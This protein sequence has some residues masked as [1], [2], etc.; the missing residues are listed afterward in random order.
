MT[1]KPSARAGEGQRTP[2]TP[3]T[4]RISHVGAEGDGVGAGPDGTLY[5]VPDTL[6]NES[7][8]VRPYQKAGQGWLARVT[9][10]LIPSPSRV[11]PV[12][13]H[14][15][16]CGGCVLQHWQSDEYAAWKASQVETALRRAGFANPRMAPLVPGRQGERRRMDLAVRRSSKSV[17][18]GLHAS[19][20]ADVV[21][22]LECPVLHRDL[23]ALV[24]SLRSLLAGM[25]AV[26]REASV[27]VNLLDN[28]PDLLLRTDAPL[29][30][31][32]RSLLVA[33]A[34]EHRIPRISWA[35]GTGEPETVCMRVPPETDL[36]GVTV[37]PPPGG[38][39]Q[40]TLEG[41]Q[42]IIAA[43]LA[44]IPEKLPPRTGIVDLYAGCG[45]ITFALAATK[46]RVA[47][48]EGDAAS[49]SAL[50]TAVG[51][52]GLSGRVTATRRDLARQPLS[53]KEF[54]G[55]TVAV[56]D[57]PHAGAAAQMAQI[58]AARV[59]TVI[60]VGC[61]PA[62]LGRDA[63]LLHDAGYRLELATPIDQFLWSARVE[64]VCVFRAGA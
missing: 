53:A 63:R 15:G 52:A 20:S 35:L 10:R 16:T 41:E 51:K 64:S 43:V 36:S 45:T 1:T 7:V 22:L 48:W 21:D 34:H 56:L 59:S 42:A 60:H 62:T 44:A 24:P 26:R 50:Q 5:Y 40:A 31:A 14:F 8:N 6:P 12:C 30:L 61:N 57:P 46:R 54:A 39:L 3:V 29:V 47:A 55:F 27:I 58:A 49:V 4:V 38:F 11:Q 9:E 37:V 19:R 32:D 25:R 33:F 23:F 13:E 28:G 2:R 17:L 18:I